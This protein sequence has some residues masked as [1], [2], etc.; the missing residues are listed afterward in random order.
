M[1]RKA[2]LS[3]AILTPL[4]VL[5]VLAVLAQ[6]PVTPQVPG[7]LPVA[8]PSGQELRFIET[9][10]GAPGPGGLTVRFRFLAPGIARADGMVGVEQALADMEYLCNA[11][12][13]PRLPVPGPVP[14]QIVISLSDRLVPFGEPT[15]EATQFFEAFRPEDGVCVWEGF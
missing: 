15:P 3:L 7:M 4:G 1:K 13:L 14:E 12:A 8:V 6:A 5:A 10:Q 11:F 9:V 2:V